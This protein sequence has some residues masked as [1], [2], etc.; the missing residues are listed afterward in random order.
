MPE[1]TKSL[2]IFLG[3]AIVLFGAISKVLEGISNIL[4]KLADVT[5][6]PMK[7]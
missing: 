2:I 3:Q 6:K 5:S 4:C 1:L 7:W